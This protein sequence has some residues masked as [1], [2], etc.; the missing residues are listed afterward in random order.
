[1]VKPALGTNPLKS[2]LFKRTTDKPDEVVMWE[3]SAAAPGDVRREVFKAPE[4]EP[5][6]MRLVAFNVGGTQLGIDIQQVSCLVRMVEITKVP[7]SAKY[8]EGMINLRGQIVPVVSLHKLLGRPRS[9]DLLNMYI[10]VGD[11]SSCPLGLTV[12]SMT[13]LYDV[14]KDQLEAP[15]KSDPLA[16]ILA[17][18]AKH[19]DGIMFVLDLEK[20]AALKDAPE[21]APKL[22]IEEQETADEAIP[23][24]VQTVLR[25]RAV[26]L[27]Q[28]A[29]D[30]DVQFKRFF[31]FALGNEK[32]AVDVADVEKA[33]MVPD[34]VPVPGTPDHVA[35]MMNHAGQILWVLDLKTLLALPQTLAGN[36][37]RVVVLDLD[38]AKFGF[39]VDAAYDVV[40]FPASAVRPRLASAEKLKDDYLAGEIYWRD[41]LTAILNLSALCAEQLSQRER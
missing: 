39:L 38:G 12:D 24:E 21:L 18:M 30:E 11:A 19:D 16:A 20:I 17:W 15:A 10:L 14:E 6:S 7:R 1:M 27:S 26:A 25:Q 5:S 3:A 29:S 4:G 36:D 23:A 41:E 22:A 35:G 33:V 9:K 8:V 2:T 37:E 32:Y 13:E 31:T 40:S 28:T 34:V